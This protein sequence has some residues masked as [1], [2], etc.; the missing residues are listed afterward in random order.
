M[1]AVKTKMA[2]SLTLWIKPTRRLSGLRRDITP[3]G[4][5]CQH[6]RRPRGSREDRP[7]TA[8]GHSG[9]MTAACYHD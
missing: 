4:F 9:G 8:L 5:I 7:L 3:A 1:Q 2:L 6:Q